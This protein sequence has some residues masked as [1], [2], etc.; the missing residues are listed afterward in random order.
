VSRIRD[1]HID[2]LRSATMQA[3]AAADNS[4]APRCAGRG[5]IEKLAVQLKAK[6]V[7][8]VEERHQRLKAAAA[9][10]V[11]RRAAKA[12]ATGKKP[13]SK[14]PSLPSPGHEEELRNR[15]LSRDAAPEPVYLGTLPTTP[16]NATQAIANSSLTHRATKPSPTS[17]SRS[18]KACRLA[19]AALTPKSHAASE[20]GARRNHAALIKSLRIHP[21]NERKFPLGWG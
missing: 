21:F 5:H 4:S 13:G 11:A 14:A 10:K 20:N 18:I 8:R 6:P 12:A 15:R 16:A 2:P 17:G 9:E 3:G 19:A 1:F 7:A